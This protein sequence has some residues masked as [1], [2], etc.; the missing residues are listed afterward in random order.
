MGISR[1]ISEIKGNICKIFAAA[2]YLTLLCLEFCKASAVPV[3]C[4]KFRIR[5]QNRDQW[6][7]RDHAGEFPMLPESPLSAMRRPSTFTTSRTPPPLTTV[8]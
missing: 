5:F 2:V 6:S 1:T 3:L 7:S 4:I 8:T